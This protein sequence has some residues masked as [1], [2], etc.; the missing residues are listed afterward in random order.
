MILVS[1]F[2]LCCVQDLEMIL[3]IILVSTL[4]LLLV[5]LT[6][7]CLVVWRRS[8]VR[9]QLQI[10][11]YICICSMH[12]C[13][14]INYRLL[15]QRTQNWQFFYRFIF[16]KVHFENDINNCHYMLFSNLHAVNLVWQLEWRGGGVVWWF[17]SPLPIVHFSLIFFILIPPQCPPFREFVS[18]LFSRTP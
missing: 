8:K 3:V 1:Y 4:S 9:Q 11:I 6:I 13:K 16:F 18:T 12:I 14:H 17:C 10:Y 15:S 5:L 7:G 2:I